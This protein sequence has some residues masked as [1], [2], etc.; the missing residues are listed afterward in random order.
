MSYES[1]S[2]ITNYEINTL[3]EALVAGVSFP[4]VET[5]VVNNNNAVSG[6]AVLTSLTPVSTKADANDTAISNAI[7]RVQELVLARQPVFYTNGNWNGSRVKNYIFAELVR[8]KLEKTSIEQVSMNDDTVGY[9]HMVGEATNNTPKFLVERWGNV[10]KWFTDTILADSSLGSLIPYA[11]VRAA[12]G[13]WFNPVYRNANADTQAF[14][15]ALDNKLADAV[16]LKALAVAAVQ[17]TPELQNIIGFPSEWDTDVPNYHEFSVK[18]N[19]FD[20]TA[21][22]TGGLEALGLNDLVASGVATFT[23]PTNAEWEDSLSDGIVAHFAPGKV[24]LPDENNN[25][26]GFYPLGGF[27]DDFPVY[28]YVAPNNPTVALITAIEFTEQEFNEFD[29]DFDDGETA[30]VRGDEWISANSAKIDTWLAL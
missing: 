25:E 7:S 23:I 16:Q 8:R 17:N 22:G 12:T 15:T 20:G 1:V 18:N 3:E 28:K 4:I 14:Y 21:N 9:T 26:P 19:T 13:I 24:M 27:T 5:Q 2:A 6:S 10:S 30:K 29:N 11:D